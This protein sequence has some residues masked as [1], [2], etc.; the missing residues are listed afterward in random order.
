[1]T[2][3]SALLALLLDRLLGEVRYDMHPLVWFGRLAIGWE[4]RFNQP[5][6]TKA[7]VFLTGL[8]GLVFLVALPVTLLVFLLLALPAWASWAVQVLVLYFCLGWQSLREHALAV[9]NALQQA[10]IVKAKHSVSMIVSRDC[11]EMNQ[12]KI[13][14]ATVE[15]VLENGND[16]IFATLLWFFL[17]GAPAALAHRLVNTLDGMWGYRNDRYE[18][19]GKSAAILD[20]WLNFIPA[21]L[22]ALSYAVVSQHWRQALSCWHRQAKKHDSPNAGV[23]MATGA[24]AL[25]IRVGGAA[26]YHG[27]RESRPT[28][29]MGKKTTLQS[30]YASLS[31]IHKSIG[32]WLLIMAA[33]S[34]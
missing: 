4:K 6:Y 17:L 23:V 26:Y 25:G 2:F 19:F 12:Q 15:S 31:L 11:Q 22:T 20:D 7:T 3:F 10:D 16:A 29:G 9:A 14:A 5:T 18:Y 28:F 30:I 24:A 27:K 32:A 1:M 21:R 33:L 8:L 13:T 34:L